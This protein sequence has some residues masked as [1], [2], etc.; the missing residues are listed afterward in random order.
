VLEDYEKEW[1]LLD[2]MALKF[3]T[4]ASKIPELSPIRPANAADLQANQQLLQ[5]FDGILANY[6]IGYC[7]PYKLRAE[8]ANV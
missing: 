1:I 5:Q 7:Y 8:I 4:T 2:I 6:A 3:R